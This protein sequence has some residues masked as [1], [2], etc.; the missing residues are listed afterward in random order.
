[1]IVIRAR[2]VVFWLPWIGAAAVT[3]WPFVLLARGEMMTARR[4]VHEGT[5]WDQQCFLVCCGLL[6][7]GLVTFFD[8]CGWWL[9]AGA[10]AGI[11]LYAWLYIVG[12][13]FGLPIGWNPFREWAERLAFRAEGVPDPMINEVLRR[14]PYRLWWI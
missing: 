4:R 9:V 2:W 3:V 11:A 5:H 6:V 13:P 12:I 10:P 1:M 8:G 7:G 14:A